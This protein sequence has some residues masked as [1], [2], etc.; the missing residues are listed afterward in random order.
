[1]Y[2]S[3]LAYLVDANNGRSAIAS[4]TNSTFRGL[5]SFVATEIAV[6]MQVGPCPRHD[7]GMLTVSMVCRIT[8]ATVRAH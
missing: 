6:P 4:A 7:L 5:F 3:M 2:A 8:L 1:M